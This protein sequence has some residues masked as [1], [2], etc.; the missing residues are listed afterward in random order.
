MFQSR[1]F[2]RTTC[3]HQEYSK[4]QIARIFREVLKKV[5]NLAQG[6]RGRE[7]RDLVAGLN[8]LVEPDVPRLLFRVLYVVAGEEGVEGVGGLQMLVRLPNTMIARIRTP[9]RFRHVH[10]ILL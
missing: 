6:L 1:D 3:A 7:E 9:P 8:V 10:G 2:S 4:P 5:R